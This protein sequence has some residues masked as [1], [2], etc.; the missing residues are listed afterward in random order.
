MKKKKWR[1]GGGWKGRNERK[2][3]EGERGGGGGY[4]VPIMGEGRENVPLIGEDRRE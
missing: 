2:E 1:R 3:W 4:D